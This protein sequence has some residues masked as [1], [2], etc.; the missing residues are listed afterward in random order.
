MNQSSNTQIFILYLKDVFYLLTFKTKPF[1]FVLMLARLKI[2]KNK[3]DVAST[4]KLGIIREEGDFADT[5]SMY[6]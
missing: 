6:R 1:S 2:C 5:L 4:S 3:L